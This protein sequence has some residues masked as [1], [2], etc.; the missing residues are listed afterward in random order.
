[1][2]LIFFG[3]TLFK[4]VTISCTAAR[5]IVRG[6]T[7]SN[8]VLVITISNSLGKI[9]QFEPTLPNKP[10]VAI[11]LFELTGVSFQGIYGH[12]SLFHFG[13]IARLVVV[14]RGF[15]CFLEK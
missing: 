3:K 2:L 8:T 12:Y 1:M 13:V 7:T 5:S 9:I 15:T 6:H 14:K 10:L 11:R 4:F